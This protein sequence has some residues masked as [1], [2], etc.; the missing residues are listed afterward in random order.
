MR[1]NGREGEGRKD[2]NSEMEFGRRWERRDDRVRQQKFNSGGTTEGNL[3]QWL[4]PPLLSVCCNPFSSYPGRSPPFLA[5]DIGNRIVTWDWYKYLKE[6][7][8][9]SCFLFFLLKSRIRFCIYS[10]KNWKKKKVLFNFKFAIISRISTLDAIFKRTKLNSRFTPVAIF[11]SKR[12][13]VIFILLVAKTAPKNQQTT[14]ISIL[15]FQSSPLS[16]N[17]STIPNNSA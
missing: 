2:R 4:H 3:S 13:N 5:K 14:S 17:N 7:P 9:L 6:K 8:L 11:K 1:K 16:A 10:K 12:R 15:H